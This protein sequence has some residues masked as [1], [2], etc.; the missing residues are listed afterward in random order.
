MPRRRALDLDAEFEELI[1][2]GRLPVQARFA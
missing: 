1:E 2:Q